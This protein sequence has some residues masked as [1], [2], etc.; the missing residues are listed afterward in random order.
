MTTQDPQKTAAQTTAPT[1]A[2]TTPPKKT[3][4][5][6]AFLLGAALCWGFGFYAQR[7]SIETVTPLWSTALRFVATM[8][9]AVAVLAW[10]RQKGVRTPWKAGV[11]L[12]V[13][14]YISF[15]LQTIAMLHTPVARVALITGLYAVFVPLLQPL[16]G[17]PAPTVLQRVGVGFA[18]VGMVLLCGVVGDDRALAV[19]PN[20]GDLMTLVMAVASAV[21]VLMIGRLAPRED[22]LSLNVVQIIAM[23]GCSLVCAPIFEGAP[24]T[25]LDASTMTALVYLAVFSTFAAFLLQML[26]QQHVSPATASV[27]MLLETPIGVIAA[28]V[29]LKEHMAGFQW[30]GAGL[31]VVAVVIAVAAE[32]R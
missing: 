26:G 15:A 7:V 3:L 21:M 31:A 11:I 19:P 14:L 23:C 32:R 18:V 30:L 22:A 9:I 17:L 13:V 20:I 4:L 10:R 8:P 16:F 25:S 12:G 5:G 28:V 2:P 29:I 24:P 1:A 6:T 27:L